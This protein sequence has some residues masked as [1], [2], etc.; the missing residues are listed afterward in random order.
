[1]VVRSRRLAEISSATFANQ[2]VQ[3]TTE[4]K[5]S[6]IITALTTMS[7][8][9]NIPQGVRSR[10]SVTTTSAVGLDPTGGGLID[11]FGAGTLGVA[12]AGGTAGEDGASIAGTC[13]NARAGTNNS[14][15][16]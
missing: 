10:G 16:T 14:T 8:A 5:T 13:A 3:V 15:A 7:A 9:R 1:M 12:S 4:A 11:V 6:P 2:I